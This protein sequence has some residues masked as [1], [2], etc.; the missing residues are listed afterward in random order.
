MSP[1]DNSVDGA[2]VGAEHRDDGRPPLSRD[3]AGRASRAVDGILAHQTQAGDG[4]DG[5]APRVPITTLDA[6]LAAALSATQLDIAQRYARAPVHALARGPL[7]GEQLSGGGGLGLLIVDGFLVRTTTRGSTAVSELFGSQDL[8]AALAPGVAHQVWEVVAP[9]RVAVLDERFADAAARLPA[10]SRA[11]ISRSL[12]QT[13]ALADRLVINTMTRVDD[14]L[15]ALFCHIARRWGRVTSSGVVIDLP[16][17]HRTLARLVGAQRPSVT[18]ALSRLHA[19][20]VIERTGAEWR[21]AIP[22]DLLDAVVSPWRRA[23][24]HPDGSRHS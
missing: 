22:A 5:A 3:G 20:G 24:V 15:V 12:Q 17:T 10:L 18:T 9:A 21:L 23:L 19:D 14:R 6:D 13:D 1:A 11:L 16:L 2:R 7:G 8:L 4:L